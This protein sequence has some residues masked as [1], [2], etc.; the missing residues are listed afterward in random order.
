MREKKRNLAIRLSFES[1]LYIKLIKHDAIYI[2]DRIT[3][4]QSIFV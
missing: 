4:N 2:C 1:G 3:S